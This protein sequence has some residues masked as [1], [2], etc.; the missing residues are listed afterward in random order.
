MTMKALLRLAR[1]YDTCLLSIRQAAVIDTLAHQRSRNWRHA[2]L[3]EHLCI[4]KGVLTRSCQRLAAVGLIKRIKIKG[5]GRLCEWALT[6]AGRAM[7]RECF[8]ETA[9]IAA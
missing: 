3:A 2:E 6:D 7:H 4:T 8:V 9:E 5:D 1:R